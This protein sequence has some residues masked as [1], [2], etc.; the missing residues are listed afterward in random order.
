MQLSVSQRDRILGSPVIAAKTEA[1]P[2]QPPHDP[3][4]KPVDDHRQADER[5]A[6]VLH[7]AAGKI[8][9]LQVPHH[10]RM[11]HTYTRDSQGRIVSAETI[12]EPLTQE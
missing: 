9:S 1:T 11:R 8:A 10:Y 4:A 6:A 5:L 3:P 12:V 2:I 7:Q